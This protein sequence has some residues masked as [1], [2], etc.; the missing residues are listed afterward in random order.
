MQSVHLPPPSGIL[1]L[2]SWLE[3]QAGRAEKPSPALPSPPTSSVCCLCQAWRAVLGLARSGPTQHYT[4]AAAVAVAAFTIKYLQFFF[5]CQYLC[6]FIVDWETGW[7]QVMRWS[8][9][10]EEEGGEGGGVGWWRWE[11]W[12][13]RA[14]PASSHNQFAVSLISSSELSSSN[15]SQPAPASQPA[16]Q[17][18]PWKEKTCSAHHQTT[19]PIPGALR[20]SA[21]TETTFLCLGSVK[22]FHSNSSQVIQI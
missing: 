6:C 1:A 17:C 21:N 4:A 19:R 2:S 9:Q 11:M 13:Y 12:W 10:E 14:P 7:E 16:S 3:C 5:S 22:L 8:W 15:L 20:L 18:V